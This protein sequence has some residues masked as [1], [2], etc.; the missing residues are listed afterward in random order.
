MSEIQPYSHEKTNRKVLDL[1]ASGDL[2]GARILDVGAGEGYFARALGE[3][4]K[5]AAGVPAAEVVRACDL[6]PEQFRYAEV[7]CDRID[8]Q[9]TLPYADSSFDA[10]CCIEVVEHVE[11]QFHLVRELHRI[12]KPGGRA[13]VTTPNVLNLNSRLRVLRTGFGVLFDPLPLRKADPVH[14]GGHIHPVSAYY[15]ALAFHRAGFRK[16]NLHVDR[17]KKS[18]MFWYVLF[19]VPVALFGLLHRLRVRFKNRAV[20]EENRTLLAQMSGFTMLTA[21]T[22]IVEGVK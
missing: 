21:R 18:A 14:L 4:V 11:N 17:L 13:V 5:Q 6:F 15:L 7:P 12:L 9:G 8:V 2:R 10:A 20:Y 16:V 19:G 22:I 3:R 1:V